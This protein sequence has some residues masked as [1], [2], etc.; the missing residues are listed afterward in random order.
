MSTTKREPEEGRAGEERG[1]YVGAL[2]RIAWQW[3]RQRIYENVVAAGYE[4][5]KPAH[6]ALFRYPTLEGRRP[7]VLAEELQITKQSVNDLLG[8]LEANGYLRRVRSQGDGRARVI[9]LTTDGRRLEATINR[10]AQDA[11]RQI[12]DALGQRR[13]AE[14][15]TALEA[16]VD[17]IGDS[18]E[19]RRR[20]P[21]EP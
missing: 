7:T 16:F 9:R 8:H 11:E 19:Q 2:M 21:V 3:V 4:D 15:H 17:L 18:G 20:A 5:V 6:V 1:R 10:A 12:A 13:F 14:M